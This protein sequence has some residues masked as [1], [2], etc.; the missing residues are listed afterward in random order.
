MDKSTTIIT[1]QSF[2][3]SKVF[4]INTTKFISL[5]GHL[6]WMVTIQKIVFRIRTA[7]IENAGTDGEVYIGFCGREFHVGTS[8]ED[9]ERGTERNYSAG[10]NA[11]SDE[12]NLHDPVLNDPRALPPL[13]SQDMDNYPIYLRFEPVGR[14]DHWSLQYISVSAAGVKYEAL[15]PEDDPAIYA[16]LGYKSGKYLYLHKHKEI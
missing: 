2:G 1:Y 16:V 9:F 13:D 10:T 14:Y 7:D 3:I 15:E 4:Q 5:L 12:V 11:L 6:V 8:Y